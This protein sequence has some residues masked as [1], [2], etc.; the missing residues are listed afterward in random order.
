MAVFGCV[1][2]VYGVCVNGSTLF[3]AIGPAAVAIMKEEWSK[4]V[5]ALEC[6]CGNNRKYQN[7]VC[8]RH[9]EVS[10]D[11]FASLGDSHSFCSE[12]AEGYEKGTLLSTDRMAA[13][14]TEYGQTAR[15]LVDDLARLGVMSTAGWHMFEYTT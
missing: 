3:T 5:T 11:T 12:G 6:R 8:L 9:A 10:L 7:E 4:N 2:L 13:Y 14:E 15:F 1:D